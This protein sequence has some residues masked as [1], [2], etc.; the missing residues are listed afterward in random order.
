MTA[1]LAA[2]RHPLHAMRISH[3]LLLISLSLL[4]PIAVLLYFTIRGIDTEVAFAEQEIAGNAYQRPLERLLDHLH[5]HNVLARQARN[6]GVSD[7]SLR[8][9]ASQIEGA[10]QLLHEVQRQFG[11]R[12][13]FTEDGLGQRQRSQAL[14][15]RLQEEWTK[16]R[17]SLPDRS[18]KQIDEAHRRLLDTVRLMIKHAGDT[19]NLILDPSLDSYY[20]MD[21]TLLA[22]PQTQDRLSRLRLLGDLLA[23]DEPLTAAEKQQLSVEASLLKE[24]DL[25]RILDGAQTALLEDANYFGTSTTLR[26]AIEGPLERYSTANRRLLERLWTL[27]ASEQPVSAA[28]F[29]QAV[30]DARQASFELWNAAAGELDTLLRIRIAH[31]QATKSWALWLTALAVALSAALIFVVSRSITDP[32]RQCVGG[33]RSLAD[34][35]LSQRT[36]VPGVGELG[37]IASAVNQASD[38]MRTAVRTIGDHARHL[39]SG[40]DRQMQASHQLSASAE[41]TSTQ[42]SIVTQASEKVSRNAQ[43]VAANVEDL[44][45]SIREIATN[46]NQAAKVANEAVAV[47]QSTNAIVTKLGASSAEIGKVLKVITTIADQTNLLALNATIE[48]ARAGEAGRG[49]AVVANSVKEL[50]RETAA[51]TED[52]G[53]KIDA[54]RHD[55]Q[56]AVRAIEQISQIVLKIHDYQNSIAGAVEEQTVVTREISRNVSEAARGSADIAANIASVAEAARETARGAASTQQAA[57]DARGMAADLERV[58]QEF[59]GIA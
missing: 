56:E 2:L 23:G 36:T 4:L 51:A 22:L 43:T 10:L 55:T 42:A 39:Q 44:G 15:S 25:E 16:L 53:R 33:L 27:V 50:S 5:R 3:K 52:I 26:A 8:D 7:D 34:K 19:S 47:A 28:P 37:Q 1:P 11:E 45:T 35:D 18:P 38:G 20:L 54:I 48:A 12:L 31:H 46:A 41:E 14:P 57:H 6:G 24:S 21:L 17:A 58:V 59:R 9:A 32:L 30:D 13:Q 40:A 29:E 49:F